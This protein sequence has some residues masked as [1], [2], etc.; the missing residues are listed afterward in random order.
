MRGKRIL[1]AIYSARA[2]ESRA[3]ACHT[4]TGFWGR[5]KELEEINFA[6]SRVKGHS[7]QLS[8][9]YPFLWIKCES[10]VTI[11]KDIKKFEFIYVVLYS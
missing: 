2:K 4:L 10:L 7:A 5:E 8:I 1:L 6:V 3:R 11:Y 9:L